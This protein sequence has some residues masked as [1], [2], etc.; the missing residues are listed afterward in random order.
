MKKVGCFSSSKPL[1]DQGSAT[2][3]TSGYCQP[4]CADKN[5]AVMG[6]TEGS[7]CWCGDLLPAEN[8]KV[9]DDKCDTPCNGYDQENCKCWPIV[10][11]VKSSPN[12]I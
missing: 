5:Q 3:Q 8:T 7:N 1:K 9:S 12:T 4:I 2:F 11:L 10:Y 6:L